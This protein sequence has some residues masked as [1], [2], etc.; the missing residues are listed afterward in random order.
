VASFFLRFLFFLG[1]TWVWGRVVSIFAV[2]LVPLH[3]CVVC[4]CVGL[5]VCLLAKCNAENSSTCFR[6]K[7]HF[8][9]FF[10]CGKN[11]AFFVRFSKIKSSR[12]LGGQPNSQMPKLFIFRKQLKKQSEEKREREGERGEGGGEES[13]R[14]FLF[15]SQNMLS[16][17]RR[18]RKKKKRKVVVQ[19]AQHLSSNAITLVQATL[20]VD[21]C[22]CL[23]LCSVCVVVW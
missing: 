15:G 8:F 13:E 7:S 22:T 9:C 6:G 2:L 4:V 19:R 20:A 16:S 18:T 1:C 23:W 3:S 17:R 5:L 11:I 10:F 14:K 21:Q 12:R